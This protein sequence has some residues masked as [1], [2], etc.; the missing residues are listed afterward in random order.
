MQRLM[1]VRVSRFGL[2]RSMIG[3]DVTQATAI[4][5]HPVTTLRA[6]DFVTCRP[7]PR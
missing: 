1:G 6:P 2:R 3:A 5:S 4:L 7:I